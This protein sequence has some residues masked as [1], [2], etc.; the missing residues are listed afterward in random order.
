MNKDI[1]I[2]LITVSGLSLITSA[3]CGKSHAAKSVPA[4]LPEVAVIEL[5]TE[6]TP[7]TVKLSGRTSAYLVAEVRPQVGGIIQ[8]RFFTEG[9]DVKAG[10]VLYQIDPALYQASYDKTKADL[11]RCEA[12]L[13]PLKYKLDRY[14]VL[15]KSKAIS[16]QNLDD[17]T[18]DFKKAEADVEVARATMDTARINL[19]YTRITA[20]ISGRIGKSNITVGALVTANHAIPLATIQ[21]ID[22][23]YVDVTQSSANLLRLKHEISNG[24]IK[25]DNSEKAKVK[26][27][28]EDGTPYPLHGD[29]KF[30]D[31]TIDQSTGSFILRIVFPN[32]NFLLLPGMFVQAVIKEGIVEKA[33]L[34]PQQGVM[35]DIKGRPYSMIV[36]ASGK[37]EHR[38]LEI[39]RAIDNNW[40]VK[41]GLGP[42][43]RVIMEGFQKI[44]H[45]VMVKAVPFEDTTLGK[46]EAVKPQGSSR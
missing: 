41:K 17:A 15:I 18:G 16:Q 46:T 12:L 22:P 4:I 29:M 24:L 26:L 40:L 9:A 34:I 25:N 30:K 35:R 45:G 44:R 42:G 36:D 19:D 10:D 23:I 31:I 2:F 3:G 33:I 7:V 43:D 14:N 8:K 13:V 39:D 11:A 28:F 21:Q 32:P 6:R 37:V 38:T 27:F 20:P 5:K 1:A